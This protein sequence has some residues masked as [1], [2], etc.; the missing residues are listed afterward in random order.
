[1]TNHLINRLLRRYLDHEP[2]TLK[3]GEDLRRD[4]E[5]ARPGAQA[6]VH[7]DPHPLEP[8]DLDPEAHEEAH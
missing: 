5:K 6:V 2:V 8:S 7:A 4:I 1:M 3:D